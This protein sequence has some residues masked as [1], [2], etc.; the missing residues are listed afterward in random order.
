MQPSGEGT[1]V[2][3]HREVL[4]THTWVGCH[5]L[6]YLQSCFNEL[7]ETSENPW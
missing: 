2:L 6:R 3:E 4:S 1:L 7:G 5:Q